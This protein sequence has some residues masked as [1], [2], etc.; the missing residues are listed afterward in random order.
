MAV[1]LNKD[2]LLKHRFWIMLAV[3][4]VLIFSGILYLEFIYGGPTE[5]RAY[6]TKMEGIA[7]GNAA[8]YVSRG[9]IEEI[10]KKANHSIKQE[11][12]LWAKLYEGQAP[13]FRFA[14]DVENAFNFYGGKF[15]QE[16]KVSK[17]DFKTLPEDTKETIHGTLVQVE[18]DYFLLKTRTKG[19]QPEKIM[20]TDS[21]AKVDLT[22]ENRQ[23]T[24]NELDGQKA[25]K[26]L[27]VKY[28]TG[29]YFGDSLTSS[30][31]SAF[32]ASYKDQIHEILKIVDPVDDKLNGVVQLRDWLYAPAPEFPPPTARFFR[33]ISDDWEQF[34][35]KNISKEIWIAQENLWLQREIYRI[36][37]SANDELS[38]F[39]GKG[40]KERGKAY[41]FSNPNFRIDLN[42]DAKG[43]LSFT[44]TNLL[45]RQQTI[46]LKFRVLLNDTPGFDPET[47]LV[48]GNPLKPKGSPSGSSHTQT[49]DAE[50]S[51]RN[52]VFGIEQVLTWQTAAIKRIDQVSFGSLSGDDLSHSHRTI[53]DGLK[54]FDPKDA[55]VAAGP[56][57]PGGMPG[58]PGMPEGPPGAGGKAAPMPLPAGGMP[59]G[60][61]GG[62]P[63]AGSN[64]GPLDLGLWSFRYQDVSDQSRRIPVAVVL[65][66]DQ[67]HLDRVLTA[68]NNSKL[69]FLSTQVLV[70]QYLGSLQPSTKLDA[71]LPGG[72]MPFGGGGPRE[73]FGGP[74]GKGS[75]GPQPM[76]GFGPTFG[77]GMG[78]EPADPGAGGQETNL[79][80]VIYG[81]MTLYQR[82][83]AAPK[84]AAAPAPPK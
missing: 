23:I 57:G 58:M 26:I 56:A 2:A 4:G 61:G 51:P 27:A 14:P 10:E 9:M 40:G 5:A 3:A 68:F 65:I 78:G 72:E 75:L 25:G 21:V 31:R 22:D 49:F 53:V 15:A 84:L 47:F 6:I 33:H 60:P 81:I 62:A 46:D 28:Q 74:R 80:V 44:I 43:K 63:G 76:P 45:E 64:K 70:N 7:K 17:G 12:D 71:G 42:L 30:E 18:K 50:K 8:K 73:I 36:I 16:I 34:V 29:R 59:G 11:T 41:S 67:D 55:E 24:L 77:P 37:R 19:E 35:A 82:Y 39:A 66:I 1:K 48:S 69:R 79:E 38:K 52:G 32:A 20:R 13:L 83:P 54:P